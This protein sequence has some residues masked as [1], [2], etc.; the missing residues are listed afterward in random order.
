M[1]WR[2]LKPKSDLV[3]SDDPELVLLE[4]EVPSEDEPELDPELDFELELLNISGETMV[5]GVN[6][7]HN[8][9]GELSQNVLA[10]CTID[11]QFI[12]VLVGWEGSANDAWVL[13][14][15]LTK[16]K[17]YLV[18]AGYPNR[19]HFLAP[20]RGVRYHLQEYGPQQ[21][22]PQNAREVFNHRHSSLRKVIERI[23]G[24]FKSR[25]TIFK[26]QPP[27]PYKTQVKLVMACVALHNYLRRESSRD[28]FKPNERV[29]EPESES[30]EETPR[31]ESLQTQAEQIE[32]AIWMGDKIAMDMWEDSVS[33]TTG[34]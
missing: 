3:L 4:E 20:Y 16:C 23:F 5:T 19:V 1:V 11:L 7:Y 21:Q 27:Y 25:F 12:Y 17:F 9:K 13:K 32:L 14:V 10:A 8:R 18:D 24:I 15:A 29:S 28:E 6:T 30:D 26:I 33:R 22:R 31:R 2:P 34:L